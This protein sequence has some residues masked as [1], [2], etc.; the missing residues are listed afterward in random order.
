MAQKVYIYLL[1]YYKNQPFMYRK[2]ASPMDPSWVI[3]NSISCKCIVIKV[4]KVY[5]VRQSIE[6]ND[7]FSHHVCMFP[8]VCSLLLQVLIPKSIMFFP[9][10]KICS[11][12]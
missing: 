1:I 7:T 4:N 5:S 2:Y 8:H 9:M 6:I 11:R 3:E 12:S 10:K